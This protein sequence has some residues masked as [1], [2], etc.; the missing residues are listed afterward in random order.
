MSP[1]MIMPAELLAKADE[2]HKWKLLSLAAGNGLFDIA[3]ARQN[4][5]AEVWA[6]D[7]PKVFE[8]ARENARWRFRALSHDP[9]ALLMSNMAPI[10]T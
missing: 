3:V 7:W 4:H 2:G 1:F 10:L 9:E 8:I 5:H 6:V